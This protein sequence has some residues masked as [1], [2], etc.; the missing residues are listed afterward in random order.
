[1]RSATLLFAAFAAGLAV[2]VA[3]SADRVEI[4][5]QLYDGATGG[6]SL[7]ANHTPDGARAVPQWRVCTDVCGG[8]VA[9]NQVFVPAIPAAGTTFEASTT[10]AE[11]TTTAR[12]DVWTGPLVQTAPPTVTGTPA[13]GQ[14]LAVQPGAWSGGWAAGDS[15]GRTFYACPTAAGDRECR[16]IDPNQGRAPSQG[17]QAT[18]KVT[19]PYAGWWI[20]AVE[21][22]YGKGAAFTLELLTVPADK[23]SPWPAPTAGP[24]VALGPLVGPIPGDRKPVEPLHSGDGTQGAADVSVKLRSR[25]KA[26]GADLRL[27]TL[28]CP[29]KCKAAVRVTQGPKKLAFT[30][31]GGPRPTA[32]VVP[33]AK[34]TRS[35]RLK[36]SAAFDGGERTWFGSVRRR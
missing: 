7:V 22:R 10:Y 17:S 36:V 3:A 9:T 35:E 6:P 4:S 13:V 33:R 28:T 25:A 31:T 18:W 11:Q 8:V 20:G 24:T 16:A 12:S 15:S 29:A 2:P 32:I 19:A 34:F 27:G 30:L 23:V 14:T 26:V 1:M 21:Y 5:Q